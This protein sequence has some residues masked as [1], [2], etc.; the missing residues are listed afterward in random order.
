MSLHFTGNLVTLWVWGPGAQ[1]QSCMRLWL[2]P[3]GRNPARQ[4]PA[5]TSDPVGPVMGSVP[6]EL[7]WLQSDLGDKAL[8]MPAKGYVD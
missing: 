6:Y 4:A 5:A 3:Q 1:W 8:G 2:Q 7:E